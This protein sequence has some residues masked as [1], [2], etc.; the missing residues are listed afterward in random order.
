[1]IAHLV[2]VES[3]FIVNLHGRR[4]KLGLWSLFYKEAL[5]V[6]MRGLPSNALIFF[7]N[8]LLTV[9]SSW[10]LEFQSIPFGEDTDIQS[11][12]DGINGCV[13][14]YPAG[15]RGCPRLSLVLPWKWNLLSHIQLFVN[16][17]TTQSMEFS[18][19]EYWSG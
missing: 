12:A 13:S 8:T 5:I 2:L 19:P 17:W 18:R 10:E 9:T 14:W 1:M 11:I 3:I 4:G 6:V 7:S 16:P 15:L